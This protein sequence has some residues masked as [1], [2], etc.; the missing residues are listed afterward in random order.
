[1]QVKAHKHKI[2]KGELGIPQLSTGDMLRAAVAQ[3]SILGLKAE[4]IMKEGG[5]VLMIL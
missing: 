1:V 5:L 4:K 2:L 3:G